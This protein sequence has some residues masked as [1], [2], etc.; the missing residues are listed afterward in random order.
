VNLKIL[1]KTKNFEIKNSKKAG[2]D[3]KIFGQ[4][5]IQNFEVTHAT[6]F[7]EGKTEGKPGKKRKGPVPYKGAT[8]GS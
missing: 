8:L 2:A 6:K 1:K 5:R 4:I 7:G 3:F